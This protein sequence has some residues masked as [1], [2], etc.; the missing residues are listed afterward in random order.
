M[1]DSGG[2]K[3]TEIT[4]IE[5]MYV[6]SY[7]TG[8]CFHFFLIGSGHH[9]IPSAPDITVRISSTQ[10]GNTILSVLSIMVYLV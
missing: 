10:S 6:Y 1:E 7:L 8:R 5:E 2:V 9:Q 3:D 4:M